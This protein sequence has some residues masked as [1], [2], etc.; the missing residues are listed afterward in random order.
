MANSRMHTK[1][2]V[3]CVHHI[4]LA[5]TDFVIVVPTEHVCWAMAQIRQI[6]RYAL[7]AGSA[8]AVY[9]RRVE[10]EPCP[11]S[12]TPLSRRFGTVICTLGLQCHQH[13]L[14]AYLVRSTCTVQRAR[15]VFGVAPARSLIAMRQ[16]A[17]TVQSDDTALL[18]I[19]WKESGTSPWRCS[20]QYILTC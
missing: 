19:G 12:R 6:V 3:R 18:T 2:H 15:S 14:H 17:K 10:L 11:T 16:G 20:G 4:L 1:L 9:V 7:R 13:A 8:L 5:A